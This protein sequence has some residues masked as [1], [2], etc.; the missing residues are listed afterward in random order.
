MGCGKLQ[1]SSGS[2]RRFHVVAVEKIFEY[3]GRSPNPATDGREGE[4]EVPRLF[5]LDDAMKYLCLV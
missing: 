5:E 2:S 3:T 4:I 1:F